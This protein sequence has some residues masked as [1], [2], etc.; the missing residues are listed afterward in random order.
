AR[1]PVPAHAAAAETPS[2]A[3]SDLTVSGDEPR[4]LDLVLAG[5]LGFVAPRE[6]RQLILRNKAELEGYGNLWRRATK[7]LGRGR[8]GHEYHLNEAQALLIC[9]LARTSMAARIRR[10]LITVFMEYRRGTLPKPQPAPEPVVIKPDFSEVIALAHQLGHA[11]EAAVKGEPIPPKVEA[12]REVAPPDEPMAPTVLARRADLLSGH[13]AIGA[14][15]SLTKRQSKR[16]AEIKAIPT[17]KLPG[18]NIVR[19]QAAQLDAWLA[20][21]A[22]SGEVR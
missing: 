9:A 6:I 20:S 12:R 22:L 17:F 2:L 7:S 5:R 14:Y 13:A 4:I 10:E 3:V 8:P 16:L 18:S 15:L 11:L 21:R 19:A 1:L